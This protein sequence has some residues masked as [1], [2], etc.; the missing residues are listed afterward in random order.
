M[1]VQLSSSNSSHTVQKVFQE[2]EHSHLIK[3]MDQ[4]ID[5]LRNYDIFLNPKEELRRDI[6]SRIKAAIIED[7]NS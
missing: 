4:M 1:K 3:K 5:S 7:Y 2:H 6:D